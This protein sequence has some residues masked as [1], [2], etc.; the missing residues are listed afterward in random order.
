MEKIVGLK[1]THNIKFKVDGS[2]NT[3]KV[4]LAIGGIQ[5]LTTCLAYLVAIIRLLFS[6]K[7]LYNVQEVM[8]MLRSQ[9][10]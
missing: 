7:G 5:L 8:L 9:S 6:L 10:S 2:L 4:L 3:T 1:S